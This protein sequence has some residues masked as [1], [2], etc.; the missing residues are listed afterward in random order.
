ME[1]AMSQIVCD[2]GCGREAIKELKNARFLC[3]EHV[4]QCPAMRA[5]NNR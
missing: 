2:F 5:K 4:A 3:A 1:M